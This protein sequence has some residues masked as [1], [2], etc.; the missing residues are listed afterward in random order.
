MPPLATRPGEMFSATPQEPLNET[1]AAKRF[2][3]LL[4]RFHYEVCAPAGVEIGLYR[5]RDHVIRFKGSV[6][7]QE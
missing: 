1:P 7:G 5:H 4:Q 3:R 2:P 6:R